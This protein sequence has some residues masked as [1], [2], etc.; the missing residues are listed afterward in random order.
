MKSGL[1][2]GS[3]CHLPEVLQDLVLE[4][5][6]LRHLLGVWDLSVP[7][8]FADLFIHPVHQ[9]LPI[10]GRAH[11]SDGDVLCD[12]EGEGVE[13]VVEKP[14]MVEEIAVGG[15]LAAPSQLRNRPS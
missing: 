10:E 3:K 15:L 8:G 4:A 1:A 11:E 12:G 13:R 9:L 7:D 14:L 2:R 5:S 6:L